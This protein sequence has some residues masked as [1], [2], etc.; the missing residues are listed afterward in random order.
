MPARRFGP[1]PRYADPQQSGLS[2][3]VKTGM[4]PVTLTLASS[5]AR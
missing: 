1:P 2:I 3:E 4:Q 5:K